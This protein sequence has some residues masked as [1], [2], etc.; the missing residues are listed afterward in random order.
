MLRS[1]L[2][3]GVRFAPVALSSAVL[4]RA[5]CTPAE[6]EA[7]MT[8]LL[9]A[10]DLKPAWLE[11]FN[12]ASVGTVLDLMAFSSGKLST[13]P[14]D[15]SVVKTLFDGLRGTSTLADGDAW[16]A[17]DDAVECTKVKTNMVKL[18]NL[19]QV[20]HGK[21]Q[22][23]RLRDAGLVPED[24]EERDEEVLKDAEAKA[25][26]LWKAAEA[27]YNVSW[28]EQRRA[29][30][31]AL[32]RTHLA[33]KRG[34]IRVEPLR[35][36][37][38]SAASVVAS[39]TLRAEVNRD[40]NTVT[41]ADDD[42]V[43]F[44]RSAQVLLAIRCTLDSLVA[45]GLFDIDPSTRTQAGVQ[46][47]VNVGSAKPRQLMMTLS[48]ARDA[49][50]AYTSLSAALGPTALTEHFEK[51]FCTQLGNMLTAGHT[52]ASGIAFLLVSAGWMSIPSQPSAAG[53]AAGDKRRANGAA[54]GT[55]SGTKD[56]GASK[57]S[58]ATSEVLKAQRQTVHVSKLLDEQRDKVKR[59][60]RQ[61]S[62][63]RRATRDVPSS[64]SYGDR[65][66]D[67]RRDQ[68]RYA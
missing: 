18:C 41:F 46:G 3:L 59:L 35:S 12:K 24:A 48:V 68:R 38:Y 50:D 31:R 44:A 1:A 2:R 13:N 66:E 64:P 5:T 34:E 65:R 32:M 29:S 33:L 42:E 19:A 11:D 47:R 26:A 62:D 15:G 49:D 7:E 58:G 6:D 57:A 67:G 10:S 56:E 16:P 51:T 25:A 55:S 39:A 9:T 63:A 8:R 22:T 17:A 61:L 23:R 14:P 54:A 40:D 27:L 37:A 28:P 53:A 30:A 20:L 52:A 4:E 36:G 21:A 43:T 45:G 60:E